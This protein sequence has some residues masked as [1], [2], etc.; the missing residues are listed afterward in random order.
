MELFLYSTYVLLLVSSLYVLRHFADARRNLPPGPPSWPLIGNLL[1]LGTLP[2]RSLARLAERHGPLMTLRLG[3]LTTVVASSADTARDVLQ[4]HDAAFSARSV[5]DAVRACAYDSFSMGWLPP[6]SPHWRALRKL[7]SGELFAPHRLDAHQ[8]IRREKVQQLV[9]HVDRL[10]REG[11]AV[12][13]SLVVFTTAL[14]LLSC[15]IFSADIA[16][17]GDRG[18]S[19]Q[20]MAVISESLQV[21]GQPNLSDFF[22]VVAPL[23]PQRLRKR[24]A[25]G[26]KQLH[27][28]FDEQ[29]ERRMRERTAG[30]LP[31]NDFMTCCST[32][33][34]GRG[35][36]R[37]MLRALLMDLFIAGSDTSAATFEWAMAEL[38]QNPSS[39]AKARDELAQVI[40]S[41]S[42]I[43][44]SDIGQLKYLQAIVKEVFRLH[45]PA[46]L[47]LPRQAEATTE[48]RGYTV[49]KGARVM[50]NVWAIGRDSELWSEPE[51]FMPERFLGK[52]M[53]YRG[54]DFELLP[55]GSGRRIC[56][57]MPLAVRMVHLMLATL[58]YRFEWKLP[59]EVEENGVDME[60]KFGIVLA[61][62][63]PLQAIAEPV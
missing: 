61:L 38:L 53:D 1:D 30:Q 18:G 9:S 2:H 51:K 11:A 52:D 8:S 13:I 6:S 26:F 40:G 37:E 14:N 60:E 15:T 49:P 62:G 23:D 36:D 56:P 25:M 29:I 5:P 12:D 31:K 22:P 44:E 4:R 54:R 63:T 50:V 35:L 39:V 17:L 47:L 20:F 16:D 59:K 34:D 57:G 43:E 41:R 28:I 19:G 55:F 46:P 45:P 33:A 3:A 42:E 24:L 58:L 32:T 21:A 7:C 10:S 27:A 48:L